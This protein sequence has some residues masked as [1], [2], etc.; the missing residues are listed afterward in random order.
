MVDELLKCSKCTDEYY[1]EDLKDGQCLECRTVRI[2]ICGNDEILTDSAEVP[3]ILE[4]ELANAMMTSANRSLIDTFGD[5]VE[6]DLGVIFRDWQGGKYTR[7]EGAAGNFWTK[8]KPGAEV[9]AAIDKAQEAMD[10]V[11]KDFETEFRADY[12][13]EFGE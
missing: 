3:S 10:A 6:T 7:G 9:E 8:E 2:V 11:V 5:D 1:A 4:D 12:I 13:E